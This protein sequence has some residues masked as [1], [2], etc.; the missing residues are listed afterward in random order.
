VQATVAATVTPLPTPTA[1]AQPANIAIPPAYQ[2]APPL[3][4]DGGLLLAIDPRK[5]P[6]PILLTPGD[7]VTYHVSQS[8]VHIAWSATPT[9]LME[10]GQTPGCVS[11]A[12]IFRRA[13]ESYQL[14]IHSLDASRPDQVQ[15]TD[16]NPSYD[17]NLTTVP[18]GRYTWEA[19]VVTLCQS[20]EIGLRN[21]L[22]KYHKSTLE[23]T[24]V[25]AVS[26]TSGTRTINWVP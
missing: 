19:N 24:L 23:T 14:I 21:D 22:S 7:N 2:P 5:Y 9:D 15:W 3:I 12:T 16:N 25:G 18:A 13:Y 17:L 8:V 10:F 4:A 26:P 11:D 6:A 1:A 20:Y